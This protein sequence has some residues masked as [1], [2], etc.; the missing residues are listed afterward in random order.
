MAEEQTV[1]G[2]YANLS[3]FAACTKGNK[4]NKVY[5]SSASYVC[6]YMFV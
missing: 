4:I 5:F 3:Y 1:Q 2:F 6:L